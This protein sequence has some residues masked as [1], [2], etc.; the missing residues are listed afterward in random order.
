MLSFVLVGI[1]RGVLAYGPNEHTNIGNQARDNYLAYVAAHPETAVGTNA[2]QNQDNWAAIADTI[3]SEDALPLPRLHFWNPDGGDNDGWLLYDSAYTRAKDRWDNYMRPAYKDGNYTVAYQELGRVMHL[4]MDM[5]VPAH[6]NLD[7]HLPPDEEWYEQTYA[8][9][10]H[11]AESGL[12]TAGT[13]HDMMLNLAEMS[14]N[15]DSN[16]ENGEVDQG[17]RRTNGFTMAEGEEI[18]QTCYRGAIRAAGGVLKLF[19]DTVQP[20]AVLVSP[21]Q[22]SIHSG[23]MGVPLAARVRSYEQPFTSASF[24]QRVGFKYAEIDSPATND[25]IHAGAVYVPE[26]SIYRLIWRNQIDDNKVWIRAVAIDK[27]GCE[28]LPVKIWIRI[29]ST[30]P[31]VNILG[32]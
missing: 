30:R 10:N 6:V 22:E 2:L 9:S 19:Y 25:W 31:E 8:P 21:V 15:Y 28:S 29:D 5:G 20:Q 32:P 17:A 13:L 18:A 1:C 14:D 12:V 7:G 26:E 4:V 11:L 16:D 24:I 23:L 27:G 3:V